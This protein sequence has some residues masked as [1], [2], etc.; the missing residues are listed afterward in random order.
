MPLWRTWVRLRSHGKV[1]GFMP[2]LT[3][4]LAYQN[5]HR[6]QDPQ[7]TLFSQTKALPKHTPHNL[8]THTHTLSN[9]QGHLKGC[10]SGSTAHCS[11]PA[12]SLVD[13][14][15]CRNGSGAAI[16]RRDGLPGAGLSCCLAWGASAAVVTHLLLAGFTAVFVSNKRNVSPFV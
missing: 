16:G 12:A 5:P 4:I 6:H 1:S 3:S 9:P 7:P 13:R 14:P 11:D 8:N 2:L 15:I 10:R